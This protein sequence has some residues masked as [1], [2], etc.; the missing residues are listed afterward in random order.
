[1]PADI[2]VRGATKVI[3]FYNVTRM[4][5]EGLD[6]ENFDLEQKEDVEELFELINEFVESGEVDIYEPP[7][8]IKGVDPDECTLEIGQKSYYPDEITL[9]NIDINELLSP[10]QDATIGDIYYVVM[11]E[12]DG[13]FLF[14]SEDE[15]IAMEKFACGYVDCSVYFDQYDVLREGYL[16][17]LCDKVLP[18]KMTYPQKIELSEFDF[19]PIQSYGQLYRVIKD[20]I[21]DVKILE[22]INYGGKRLV[23]ANMDVDDFEAN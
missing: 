1:M 8:T 3:K 23:G 12:G 20:P 10:I 7:L 9:K 5:I 2:K 17:L 16:D 4:E 13:T 22:R 21:E 18:E 19:E 15:Q 6:F 11:M 14:E